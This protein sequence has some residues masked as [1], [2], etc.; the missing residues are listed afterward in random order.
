MLNTPFS[1]WPSYSDEEIAVAGSV[2]KSN[3]VNYW[4]G[5]EGKLFE[6]EFALWLGC[7]H[8]V[9]VSNGTVAL[10]LALRALGV[11]LGDEVVVPSRTFIATA[12][13][14]IACGAKPVFADVDLQ[15]QGLSA[16]TISAVISGATK[17]IICVHLAGYPCDMDPIIS[18]ASEHSLFVVEDCAQAH[19]A[20]YKGRSVGSIGDVGAWSFC[21]DKIMTTAGE[22]GMVTTNSRSLWE[23]VWSYKDHGK[24]WDAVCSKSHPPGFRWLHESF[25]SNMRMPEIQ[26]AVGRIQLR[27]ML[28]WSQARRKNAGLIWA[29]VATCGLFEAVEL[30]DEVEHAFYKC[31]LIIRP[32]RLAA[33]WSRD[34]IIE[35]LVSRG[36]PCFSGSCSEIYLEQ[37]FIEADLQPSEPLPNA[38]SLGDNSLMFLVHPTLSDAEVEMTCTVLL[39]V[40]ARAVDGD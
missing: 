31:Y 20:K 35:E 8:A 25:G 24:S 12:S 30:S 29:A 19:G 28:G 21:Q 32:E 27:N 4:T 9:A 15:T 3:K 23:K 2:M 22:G 11:G 39:E 38:K 16:E 10:E 14:V 5:S 34:R 1:P 13:A 36:V 6:E 26:A 18:L 37:A 33:E 40:A 7:K 17:A